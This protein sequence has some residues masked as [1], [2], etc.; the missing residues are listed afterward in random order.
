M[1]H[2]S[3]SMSRNEDRQAQNDHLH[4]PYLGTHIIY[5]VEYEKCLSAKTRN[6]AML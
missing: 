1:R 2:L 6:W 5:Q 3:P 4:G